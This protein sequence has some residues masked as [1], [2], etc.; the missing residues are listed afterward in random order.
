M[1]HSAVIES[2]RND[3]TDLVDL[4]GY[5]AEKYYREDTTFRYILSNP[6]S[7]FLVFIKREER[8]ERISRKVVSFL[9]Y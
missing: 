9:Q 6:S 5:E 8:I 1:K 7:D 4:L 2:F 3:E